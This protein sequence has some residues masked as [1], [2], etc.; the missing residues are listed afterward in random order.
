MNQISK[1]H[2]DAQ[3]LHA[4]DKETVYIARRLVDDTFVLVKD[5][6][7]HELDSVDRTEILAFYDRFSS[8][9]TESVVKYIGS[10]QEKR[11]DFLLKQSISRVRT[12]QH[13]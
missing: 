10:G 3:L 1:H 12:S 7:L 2:A 9:D 11:I 8:L 4:N 6:D 13:C 5:I